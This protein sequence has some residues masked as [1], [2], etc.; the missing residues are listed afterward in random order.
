MKADN[1]TVISL[2]KNGGEKNHV[3]FGSSLKVYF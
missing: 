3:G 1:I 2:A